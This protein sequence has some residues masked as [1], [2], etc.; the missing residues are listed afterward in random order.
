MSISQGTP[1]IASKTPELGE[2]HGTDSP[3]WSSEGINPANISTLQS[4]EPLYVQVDSKY[5][6][7][8]SYKRE[9]WGDGYR[10]RENTARGRADVTTEA[11]TVVMWPQAKECWH[12]PRAGKGKEGILSKSKTPLFQSSDTYFGLPPSRIMREYISVVLSHQVYGHFSQ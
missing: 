4:P 11:E 12:P 3:S 5:N 7:M 8:C 6:H 2:R 1:K 9:V 10:R